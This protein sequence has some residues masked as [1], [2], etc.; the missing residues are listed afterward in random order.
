MGDFPPEWEWIRDL[1]EGGQAHTFVV[2][3]AD[4]SDSKQYVLKRLKNPKREDYFEREI[5]ACETLDHSNVVRVLRHGHTPK[6]KPFLI[7]EYCS[8]GS[9]Q[10]RRK[11]HDPGDG[12]RFFRQIVEGVA[13]AHAHEPPIH[14]LDLKPENILLKGDQPVVGDFG[15]CFVEGEEVTLTKDGPRGSMYYCAPELRN[16]KISGSLRLSAADVYSLGKILYWLF[17][18]DVYDGHEEDYAD[19]ASRRLATLFPS[20]PQFAFI[21]DLVALMVCRNPS[22]RLTSAVDLAGHVQRV[23]DRIERGGRALDFRIPQHCLYC[24]V[25]VYRP[26][27]DQV[28]TSGGSTSP[29]FPEIDLHRNPPQNQYGPTLIYEQLKGVANNMLGFGGSG[30]GIPLFLICDYCGNVQYFRLDLTADGHGENWRP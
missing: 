27:H 3:R 29:K 24:G 6:G 30:V 17:T 23:V 19:E 2:R 9:L 18:N 10:Q 15:I 14:H 7:T 4:G 5:Q 13:H 22:E 28:H 26:A 11:F 20:Y 16:P 21:D 12:L 1:H 25:G 8:G